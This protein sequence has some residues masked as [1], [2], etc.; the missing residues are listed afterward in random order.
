MS[1]R[2]ERVRVASLPESVRA[3]CRR[4]A[5]LLKLCSADLKSEEAGLILDMLN[6]DWTQP[7]KCD[8]KL[9]HVCVPGCCRD[10]RQFKQKMLDVLQVCFGRL[11][12]TPLLY[13]LP[14]AVPSDFFC[15]FE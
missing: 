3:C 5:E 1:Q 12:A 10:D 14:A 8:G 4:N 11:Y 15:H 9:T 2:A 6:D 13:R 7:R